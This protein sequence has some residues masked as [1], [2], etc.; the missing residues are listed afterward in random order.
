M[1]H[2]HYIDDNTELLNTFQDILTIFEH[3]VEVFSCPVQ[4]LAYCQNETYQPP[5]AIFTD[6]VMPKM[7]GHTLIQELSA[8]FPQQRFITVSGF[9]EK[10]NVQQQKTCLHLHK[11]FDFNELEHILT[12]IISCNQSIPKLTAPQCKCLQGTTEH[13]QSQQACPKLNNM[14]NHGTQV[15]IP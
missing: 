15:L 9:Q 7:N 10:T 1:G 14:V 2:F 6:V 4:Y 3:S 11:P 12:S 5:D 13:C 8:I